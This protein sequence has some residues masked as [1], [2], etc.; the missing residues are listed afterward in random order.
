FE[1]KLRFMMC[2]N[3]FSFLLIP[4]PLPLSFFFLM[5]I[6]VINSRPFR[7]NHEYKSIFF[8]HYLGTSF[9]SLYLVYIII[10]NRSNLIIGSYHY[11]YTTPLESMHTHNLSGNR[12]YKDMDK[13]LFWLGDPQGNKQAQR[14]LVQSLFDKEIANKLRMEDFSFKEFISVALKKK[15]DAQGYNKNTTSPISEPAGNVIRSSEMKSNNDSICISTVL[16][17]NKLKR[18]CLM[19]PTRVMRNKETNGNVKL[20]N[21]SYPELLPSN[22]FQDNN[23][24]KKKKKKNQMLAQ[25]TPSECALDEFSR[26]SNPQNINP[27]S[28]GTP[29]EAWNPFESYEEYASKRDAGEHLGFKKLK[30]DQST[31][32]TLLIP[33]NDE[34]KISN[35]GLSF[36]I[37]IGITGKNYYLIN[38]CVLIRKKIEEIAQLE[39]FFFFT[40]RIK[41]S[42]LKLPLK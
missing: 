17:T 38:Q 36:E 14:S 16:V 35:N 6:S 25:L 21:A 41:G 30:S 15:V 26:E 24:R 33:K 18:I 29:K 32:D 31:T 5:T 7:M 11:F 42:F 23:R 13:T 34:E 19:K 2:C 39:N 3:F 20:Q 4:K 37:S 8:L 1:R 28:Q 10:P 22:F 40:L 27:K 12:I 9:T